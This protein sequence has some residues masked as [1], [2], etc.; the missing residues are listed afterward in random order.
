MKL[1][2]SLRMNLLRYSYGGQ[3]LWLAGLSAAST[4][5]PRSESDAPK[6]KSKEMALTH[7]FLI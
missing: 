6:T 3:E 1:E 2:T 5:N 4:Q 7:Q